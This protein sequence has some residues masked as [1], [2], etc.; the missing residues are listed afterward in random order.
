MA[1]TYDKSILG[2]GV[3]GFT[4]GIAAARDHCRALFC[5]RVAAGGQ[6]LT[7]AH[8]DNAPGFPEGAVG[9]TLGP[10]VQQ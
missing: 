7:C 4:T 10:L 5:E 2:G 8:I 3:A 9:S 1:E 6:V